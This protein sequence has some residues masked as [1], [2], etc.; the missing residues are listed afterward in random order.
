ML[1]GI[2]GAGTWLCDKA[3][4][5]VRNIGAGSLAVGRAAVDLIQK[6]LNILPTCVSKIVPAAAAMAVG[7]SL[8]PESALM[9]A[10]GLQILADALDAACSDIRRVLPIGVAGASLV[11]GVHQTAK[12]ASHRLVPGP[13][14]VVVDKG[15]IPTVDSCVRSQRKHLERETLYYALA[16]LGVATTALG[17]ATFVLTPSKR[18]QALA[19]LLPS[20]L[21]LVASLGI[22]RLD[23]CWTD[24][25]IVRVERGVSKG[26]ARRGNPEEASLCSSRVCA[27]GRE[28]FEWKK[29]CIELAQ[30]E[31]I[32]SGVYCSGDGLN[33]VLELLDSKLSKIENFRC[34]MM[35]PS[36][37]WGLENVMPAISLTKIYPNRFVWI[38]TDTYDHHTEDGGVKQATN[39]IKALVVDGGKMMVLGG[40]NLQDQDRK[41]D[42]LSGIVE[43][44]SEA[45]GLIEGMIGGQFRDMD[46]VFGRPLNQDCADDAGYRM[47]ETLLDLAQLYHGINHVLGNLGSIIQGCEDA[48]CLRR[49]FPM[50]DPACLI[51]SSDDLK[52]LDHRGRVE[53]F[54]QGPTDKV[55]SFSRRLSTAIDQAQQSIVI[56]HAYFNPSQEV[57]DALARA[58]KERSVEVIITSNGDD[59]GRSTP[60]A[61]ACFV[62]ANRARIRE[63]AQRL[64]ESERSLLSVYEFGG[65]GGGNGP[66]QSTLHKKV[67]VIDSQWVVGGSSNMG[68]KSM[69]TSADYEVNFVA[70][71]TELALA[72]ES[73]LEVDRLTGTEAD[74]RCHATRFDPWSSP[75][76]TEQVMAKV[77]LGL[78]AQ[79]GN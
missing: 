64:S 78:F 25:V 15:G 67:C 3:G 59:A 24:S 19:L 38:D 27:D 12:S 7:M 61:H 42:G 62:P 9:V 33:E 49:A 14:L 23:E 43:Q 66:V 53:V 21:F 63:L 58:M 32:M 44:P 18:V 73:V 2:R 68:F 77:Y 1:S 60:V 5:G 76:W 13:Q 30:C 54:A 46:W 52:G 51:A 45:C 29:R 41:T 36:K 48:H 79:Y 34:L 50:P 74:G 57:M 39:H 37:Q 70:D 71:S 56:H 55:S 65:T 72:T 6:S 26:D 17:A 69:E 40:T 28:S 31:V 35:G 22:K 11:R 4:Q 10:G 47:R 8:G 75:A 16:I 20:L